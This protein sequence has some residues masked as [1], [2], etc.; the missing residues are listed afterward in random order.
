[1]VWRWWGLFPG[2]RRAA[3]SLPEV[4]AFPLEPP[5]NSP[6]HL[7]T[8]PADP[9]KAHRRSRNLLKLPSKLLETGK[10]GL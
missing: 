7:P 8:K 1:M 10:V 6:H 5:G 4:Q 2:G 9:S 3:G